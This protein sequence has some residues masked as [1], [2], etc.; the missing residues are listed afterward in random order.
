MVVHQ[1]MIYN[2]GFVTDGDIL[3]GGSGSSG[4]FTDFSGSMME[5]RLWSE[6]ISQSVFDNHVKH[7]NL[8]TETP[9]HHTMII[10][11]SELN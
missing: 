5:F 3:L 7:Q 11:F 8:I 2:N 6:V 1:P 10:Y 4:Y 9:H